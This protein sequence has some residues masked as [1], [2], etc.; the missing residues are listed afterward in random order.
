MN[1]RVYAV[2]RV[3]DPVNIIKNNIN[4]VDY[5]FIYSQITIEKVDFFL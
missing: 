3:T 5:C 2:G 1:Q 4:T